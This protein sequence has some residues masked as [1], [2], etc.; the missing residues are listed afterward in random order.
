MNHCCYILHVN[1]QHVLTDV[2]L[3]FSSIFCCSA[4]FASAYCNGTQDQ[5]ECVKAALS[6]PTELSWEVSNRL[7]SGFNPSLHFLHHHVSHLVKLSV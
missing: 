2:R 5:G 6:G 3:F 7:E 4:V 1:N